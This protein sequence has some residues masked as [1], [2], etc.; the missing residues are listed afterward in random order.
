MTCPRCKGHGF[1]H[2]LRTDEDTGKVSVVYSDI[3]ECGCGGEPEV[4]RS[5][6]PPRDGDDFPC[7]RI[8]RSYISGGVDSESLPVSAPPDEG[9]L[10]RRILDLTGKVDQLA[11]ENAYFR[12]LF[13]EKRKPQQYRGRRDDGG[14]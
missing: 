13:A 3:I 9:V 12:T 1:L 11:G 6:I 4:V 5:W 2:P 14:F 8:F 10:A 7:S